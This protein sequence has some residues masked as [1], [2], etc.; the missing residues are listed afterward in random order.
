MEEKK[1]VGR[2]KGSTKENTK[3]LVRFRCDPDEWAYFMAHSKNAS[4]EIQDFIASRNRSIRYQELMES[5]YGEDWKKTVTT[6][7]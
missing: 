4:K 6:S 1:K 2:P 5:K 7:S 3:K